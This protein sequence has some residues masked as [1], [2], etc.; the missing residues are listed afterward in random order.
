MYV[1][2]FTHPLHINAQTIFKFYSRNN[3]MISNMHPTVTIDLIIKWSFL[4]NIDSYDKMLMQL[5]IA[6]H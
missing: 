3:V 2:I 4:F 5:M 1:Q 6:D